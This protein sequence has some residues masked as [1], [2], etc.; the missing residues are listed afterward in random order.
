MVAPWMLQVGNTTFGRLPRHC[1]P[2]P[3]PARCQEQ[4]LISGSNNASKDC[5]QFPGSKMARTQALISWFRTL[6]SLGQFQ[7]KP[8]LGHRLEKRSWL[9]GA[10]GAQ[11]SQMPKE[12]SFLKAF[13]PC[14]TIP[15]GHSGGQP[16]GWG[17]DIQQ[18][19]G[20][21][22]V[23]AGPPFHGTAVVMRQSFPC[24]R[25]KECSGKHWC[26]G[27]AFGRFWC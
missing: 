23:D 5:H 18:F 21:T 13:C 25:D 26:Y 7:A 8:I 16:R 19:R 15:P 11:I 4:L 24:S 14:P 12:G 9:L 20:S 1:G 2:W 27:E 17:N 10:G 6:K 22:E 3:P